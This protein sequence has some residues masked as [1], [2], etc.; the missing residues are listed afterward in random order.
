MK[1]LTVFTPTYNRLHTIYRLYESLKQQTSKEFIWLVIDDGSSDETGTY[2]QYLI[3]QE[4][5]FEIRYIYKE[6]GGMHT[7]HNEAYRNIDTE[8]CV[9]ID[10]DDTMPANAVELILENWAKFGNEDIAGLIGLDRDMNTGNIIGTGF[11]ENQELTTLGRY[12]AEGGIGD[13]KLVYRTELMKSIP[14][15]PVFEGE[16]Y[17]GLVYKYTL[18]DQIQPLRIVNEV[19]CNVEYQTD[20]STNTM[21]KSYLKNPRGFSFLRINLM[22]YPTS[23]KRMVIDCIHYCSSC[24]ISG[25]RGF[26]QKSPNPTLTLLCIPFGWVMT[27]LIRY[28][29]KIS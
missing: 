6:N 14:E 28:K 27:A 2:I 8:L 17:V 23:K 21:W 16:K 7:A 15:Y 5:T 25:E 13:K 11:K 19:F 20:G 22:K 18:A 3:D 29:A 9:C 24:Q 10:S 1:K 4:K 26:I 12:Y